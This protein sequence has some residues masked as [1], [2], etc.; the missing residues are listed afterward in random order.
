MDGNGTVQFTASQFYKELNLKFKSMISLSNRVYFS[1]VYRSNTRP[2]GFYILLFG[3]I[4][5]IENQLNLNKF[6]V[7][8]CLKY[9]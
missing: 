7:I 9:I 4:E 5:M 1:A 3:L 6:S 2:Y 8:L